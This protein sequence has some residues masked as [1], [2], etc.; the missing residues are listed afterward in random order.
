M[1]FEDL[2][3]DVDESVYESD[4]S[5]KDPIALNEL[6][7]DEVEHDPF[8]FPHDEKV[9]FS[10]LLFNL[11]VWQVQGSNYGDANL[12]MPL[13]DDNV[14]V[15][16]ASLE[17]VHAPTAPSQN[18]PMQSMGSMEVVPLISSNT[19]LIQIII[20]K[21]YA[22]Q[23]LINTSNIQMDPL[24]NP[25]DILINDIRDITLELGVGPR[26]VINTNAPQVANLSPSSPKIARPKKST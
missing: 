24:I 9:P 26:M 4:S 17:V 6:N 19:P 7:E 1:L 13:L 22:Q 14:Q 12:N 20:S 18:M 2:M 11:M 15:F 10:R 16:D 21:P 8:E 3:S 5:G 23:T 25:P